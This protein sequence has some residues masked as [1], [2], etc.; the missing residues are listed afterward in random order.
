MEGLVEL[1]VPIMQ[2][3][4]TAVLVILFFMF[5]VRPLLNYFIVNREIEQRKKIN[6]GLIQESAA[7]IN[8][9]SELSE[10][11]I[12]PPEENGTRNTSGGEQQVLNSLASDDTGKAVDL[13]KQWVNTDSSR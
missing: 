6:E 3:F 9:S 7:A 13:V 2:L 10:K 12:L 5:I 4:S 1:F 8:A 11:S